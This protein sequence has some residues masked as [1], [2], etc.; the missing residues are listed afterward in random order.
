MPAV[1]TVREAGL[2]RR[3]VLDARAVVGRD[4]DCDV[5]L[6]S[7]SV[8]RRHAV[9]ERAGESWVARDL[10]SANGLFVEGKRLSEATLQPGASLRFGDV[11]A[12]FETGGA[13][14]PTSAERLAQSLSVAPA[15][16]TRHVALGV[17]VTL[18]ILALVA[19]TV[20]ARYCDPAARTSTPAAAA[21]RS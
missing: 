1:L 8:S 5:V 2:E 16:K 4:P 9:L 12:T 14:R 19:A 18:S 10:G 21:P 7:R 6:S 17:V 20:W 3:I 11:E 15:R 13:P